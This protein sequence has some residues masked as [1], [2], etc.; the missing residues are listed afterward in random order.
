[1]CRIPPITPGSASSVQRF[2]YSPINQWNLPV[3]LLCSS[4]N[5]SEG[6]SKV[7]SYRA[8]NIRA[9]QPCAF[10]SEVQRAAGEEH[11]GEER[12]RDPLRREEEHG[13]VDQGGEEDGGEEQGGEEHGGVEQGEERRTEEQEQGGEEDGGEEQEERRTEEGEE[14]EREQGGSSEALGVEA[15]LGPRSLP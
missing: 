13:G 14:Q 8:L 7:Q 2:M 15:A 4:T 11:R 6:C 1:M 3:G 10:S 5:Q 9:G 12:C